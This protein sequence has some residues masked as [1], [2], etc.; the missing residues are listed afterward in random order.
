MGHT[1]GLMHNM[2]ASNLWLPE[3]IH[4]TE[5]T[6]KLGLIG[7]VMD[8]P[9]VN[10]NPDH[11]NQG[12]YYTSKPGP[13]DLWAIEYAYSPALEDPIAE[14][15]RL[16]KILSRSTEPEL[17]FGNDADDMRSPGKGIDPRVMIFD[18]SGDAVQY[19]YDRIHMLNG[20][21][22]KLKDKYSVE[23]EGY[24]QLLSAYLTV[25]GEIGNAT[26]VMSRYIGGVYVE[27]SVV[28]Q[29]NAKTPYTP[30]PEDYQRKAM[31]YLGATLFAPDAFL[32][33]ESLYNTLQRQRRGFNFFVNTED[34]KIYE[35][36][37][38]MQKSVLSHIL[39]R[40]TLDRVTN[41]ERYGNTYSVIE[42]MGDL[43]NSLFAADLKGNVNTFRANAQSL[44]VD[45]LIQ[46]AGLEKSSFYN[47]TSQAA[48]FATLMYIHKNLK[49]NS[50]QGNA[51]TRAHRSFLLYTISKA[52]EGK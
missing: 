40:A 44:Y 52:L 7:S 39:S 9:A 42:I 16:N 41:S 28:G 15:A 48:A 31:K 45:A 14:E 29:P 19:S 12:D 8:Y 38:M 6:Q 30:V 17:T 51:E 18:I 10:I 3:D 24:N 23:G 47:A 50:L 1:L 34:P 33:S 4:N 2:K 21:L 25:T 36:A 13:Y 22:P 37:L 5:K 11:K 20:I 43:E 46:I 26:S 49:A 35:R 32:A 27:R